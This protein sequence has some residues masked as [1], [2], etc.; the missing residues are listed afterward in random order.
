MPESDARPNASGLVQLWLEHLSIELVAAKPTLTMPDVPQMLPKRKT[1]IETTHAITF[2]FA[3]RHHMSYVQFFV[4][5]QSRLG[6][7]GGCTNAEGL[8]DV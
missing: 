3:L 2:V 5:V 4:S 1:Q 7:R 8:D 6:V